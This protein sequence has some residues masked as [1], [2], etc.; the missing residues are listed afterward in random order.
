MRIRHNPAN[1]T[2]RAP[3]AYFAAP[4][5]AGGGVQ[6]NLPATL[7]VHRYPR[8]FHFKKNKNG[9]LYTYHYCSAFRTC[10]IDT[11]HTW[12]VWLCV[13]AVRAST[14]LNGTKPLSSA[15]FA[16][17][18]SSSAPRTHRHHL[19]SSSSLFLICSNCCSS[20]A[21]CDSSIASS[22]SSVH[23]GGA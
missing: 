4:E 16:H 9:R 1:Y 7:P 14:R 10:L 12:L 8:L 19:F 6:C 11:W 20:I 3:A 22:C 5:P 2:I 15:A 23:A 17:A 13:S 18:A 21:A